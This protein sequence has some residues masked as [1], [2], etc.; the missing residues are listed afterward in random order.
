MSPR[1]I[2]ENLSFRPDGAM[3]P[4]SQAI[5]KVA[6][7]LDSECGFS[8]IDQLIAITVLSVC[9][10]VV[11]TA[12]LSLAAA[13]GT[14]SN[15]D[16]AIRLQTQLLE[17]VHERFPLVAGGSLD[18]ESPMAGYSLSVSFLPDGTAVPMGTGGSAAFTVL[19][20]I[21]PGTTRKITVGVFKRLIHGWLPI[22]RTT[23]IVGDP[24]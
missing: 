23:R 22:H 15:E 5:S 12:I 9:G 4:K 7:L 13:I 17:R 19:W 21:Q 1:P 18:P 6:T 2:P 3:F 16:I 11:G 10:L 24:Q 14:A 8:L 20:E